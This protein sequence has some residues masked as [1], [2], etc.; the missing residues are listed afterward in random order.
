MA[1]NRIVDLETAQ[2]LAKI[3]LEIIIA[4]GFEEEAHALLAKKKNIRLMELPWN[5][6]SPTG[7][8]P[9]T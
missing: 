6:P 5:A 4:P 1:L 7:R 2:E 3:F 9:W 8:V